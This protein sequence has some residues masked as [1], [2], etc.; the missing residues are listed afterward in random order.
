MELRHLMYFVAVAEERHFGR[1][2]QRL[3]M[4]QPPLSQ[5]IRQL[6]EELGV[7]LLQRNA[8]RVELTPAG[9]VFLDEARKVLAQAE[10]AVELARRAGRGELGRL[11]VGF[12]GSATYDVLPAVLRMFRRQRPGVNVVLQ[13]LSTPQQEEALLDDRIDVGF[14]R[15]PMSSNLIEVTVVH[16]SPCVLALPAN[17]PLANRPSIGLADLRGVP[18]VML[19][20]STWAGLYD[21]VLGLCRQHGFSPEIQQEAREFQTVIGLVAGGLGVAVVPAS[22]RNL[23]SRDVVYREIG[24]LPD[25]EMG[26]AWRRKDSS[27]V[28]AAFLSVARE[29]VRPRDEG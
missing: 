25:M 21:T 7:T 9:E 22:A 1:A 14:V 20:R 10:R 11:R 15:P 23:H 13:E 28:L 26:V 17:H 18:L 27:P 19:A 4:T 8:R 5:Q 16:R 24:G 3:Q 12:V 2:A 6:E 29:A